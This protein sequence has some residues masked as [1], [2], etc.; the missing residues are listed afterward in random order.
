M[1]TPRRIMLA[2]VGLLA[3]AAG[4]FGYARGLGTCDGLPPLPAGYGPRAD[5]PGTD[6]PP[7]RTSTM[8]RKFQMAFGA[9]CPV[10]GYPIKTELKGRHV[11][12]AAQD[13]KIEKSG[14]RAG[15]VKLLSL[16]LAAFNQN[17]GAGGIPEINTL[18]C[19]VAYLKFD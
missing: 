15:W 10:I 4:Y 14:E 17:L 3:F 16:S 1:W 19:D 18:Y 2:L 5:V 7:P 13:F 11:L 9:N 6:P 12:V 8:D